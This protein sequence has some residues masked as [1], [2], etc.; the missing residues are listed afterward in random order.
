MVAGPP[1][2]VVLTLPR[3]SALC[4]RGPRTEDPELCTKDKQQQ[5]SSNMV[6]ARRGPPGNLEMAPALALLLAGLGT[7]VS[8]WSRTHRPGAREVAVRAAH[9]HGRLP[10][11]DVTQIS[12][13][14][15]ARQ[16]RRFLQCRGVV[17]CPLAQS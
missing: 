7:G 9:Q 17:G 2:S 13:G 8:S 3:G 5:E 10:F 14:S 12:A 16:E 6:L 15:C 11:L 4:V 1:V